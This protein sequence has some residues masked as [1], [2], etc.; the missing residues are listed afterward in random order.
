MLHYEYPHQKT[1][2]MQHPFMIEQN[3]KPGYVIDDHLSSSAVTNGIKRPTRKRSGPPYA[4]YSVLL[5]MGF[6]YALHV[7]TQAV[8]SYTAIPPLPHMWR[9]ISVALSLESPPPDVIWHPA[10]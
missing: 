6:T 1:F 4:F 7:T 2:I 8:V 9:Y 10:L 3:D 5:R